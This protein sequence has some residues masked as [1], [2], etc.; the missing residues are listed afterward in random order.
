LI[1]RAGRIT[2]EQLNRP[3]RATEI[4]QK[5]ID[6]YGARAG[7]DEARRLA[8]GLGDGFRSRGMAEQAQKAYDQAGSHI[9]DRH[10]SE[11]I[12]RGNLARHVEA[13]LHDARFQAAGEFLDTWAADL[14]ADKLNGYWSWMAVRLAIAQKR[15][16]DAIR[17]AEIL[18]G[19]NPRSNYGA[20]LL[21]LARQAALQSD[22]P[23]R[24]Q[25][26]LERIV[27]EFPESP[28]AAEAARLLQINP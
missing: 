9:P 13:Y 19:A 10:R 11:A 26:L 14:P 5:A 7:Q 18:T 4:Y 21:M 23:Q 27:K 2:L 3:E 15:Y 24:G 12:Y 1:D 16:G 25:A 8:V 22:Q 20:Q 6:A 17:E 28:L